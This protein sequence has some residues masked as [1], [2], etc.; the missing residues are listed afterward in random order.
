MSKINK[1]L[2]IIPKL[3]TNAKCPLNSEHG[4][5]VHY[6]NLTN[7]MIKRTS[8]HLSSTEAYNGCYEFVRFT[9]CG[10]DC[11]FEC[12]LLN[13]QCQSRLLLESYY[14]IP[15]RNFHC[16]NIINGDSLCHL[17]YSRILDQ[18]GPLFWSEIRLLFQ[19]NIFVVINFFYHFIN[20]ASMN[21]WMYWMNAHKS[22]IRHFCISTRHSAI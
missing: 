9:I 4:N 16:L 22:T 20:S 1:Q 6:T 12:F 21:T 3:S 14:I 18:R 11:V 5:G 13:F 17:P 8:D 7:P 19:L 2:R 10:K 15:I